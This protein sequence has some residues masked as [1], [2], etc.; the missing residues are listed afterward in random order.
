[1]DYAVSCV[2]YKEL[3]HEVIEAI[4]HVRIKKRTMLPC[5]LVGFKRDKVTK[6]ARVA[7]ATSS[8]MWNV[9]FDVGPR[10]QIRFLETLSD[11]VEWI[12]IQQI[13]TIVDFGNDVKTKYEVTDDLKHVKCNVDNESYM[14]GAKEARC[15]RTTHV[16][17]NETRVAHWRK[18]IAEMTPS[19]SI[20]IHNMFPIDVEANTD[21]INMPFDSEISSSIM[22]RTTVAASEASV[23]NYSM[24]GCW[25]ITNV[26]KIVKK[27]KT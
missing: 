22:Q 3:G 14:H 2:K 18:I 8:I 25:I 21:D 1:M 19:S 17:I 6:E 23:K 13:S 24:G 26:A 9:K 12:K 5:D 20:I 10:P 27:K 11:F 7:N 16:K 15:G 4:N